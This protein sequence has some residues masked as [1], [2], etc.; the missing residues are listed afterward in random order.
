MSLQPP[1][2]QPAPQFN[3][4][5]NE[6]C[7]LLLSGIAELLLLESAAVIILAWVYWHSPVSQPTVLTW[8]GIIAVV[9][10]A[11]LFILSYYRRQLDGQEA[12]P[13]FRRMLSALALASPSLSPLTP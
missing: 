10:I 8:F 5:L 7:Q 6:Q 11:R 13:L 12:L 2:F 3:G 1:S 9:Q 4:V